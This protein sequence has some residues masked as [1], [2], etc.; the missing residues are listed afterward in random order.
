MSEDHYFSVQNKDEAVRLRAQQNL[1]MRFDLPVYE[2]YLE[3]RKGLNILDLGCN[4]GRYA[5][6]RLGRF[7]E[8]IGNYVGIEY[9]RETV[10]FARSAYGSDNVTYH[11]MDIGDE[12]FCDNVRNVMKEHNIGKFD[13]IM[14]SLVMLHLKDKDSAARKIRSLMSDETVFILIDVDDGLNA[15]DPDPEGYIRKFNE[16]IKGIRI[17]GSRNFGRRIPE[18]FTKAGFGSVTLERCGINTIG[19]DESERNDFFALYSH[20]P[21][22][23]QT[24]DDPS[25]DDE[26]RWV[27]DNLENFRKR[28]MAPDTVMSFG[29]MLYSLRI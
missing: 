16:I 22:M 28:F 10:E 14:M 6:M 27:G 18:T 29:F 21:A 17:C 13:V 12:D 5:M 2:K 4:N 11:W 7:P 20:I 9:D 1:M 19:M 25:F 26:K 8:V 24:V 23:L 15:M 3:G